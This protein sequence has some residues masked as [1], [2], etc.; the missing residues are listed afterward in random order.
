MKQYFFGG[1][2][3]IKSDSISVLRVLSQSKWYINIFPNSIELL[4]AGIMNAMVILKELLPTKTMQRC[5]MKM[6]DIVYNKSCK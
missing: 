5:Q 2:T 6:F 3:V 1:K 4:S